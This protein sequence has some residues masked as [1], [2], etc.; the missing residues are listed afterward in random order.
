MQDSMSIVSARGFWTPLDKTY[1]DIRVFHPQAPSNASKTITQMYHHHETSKKREYNARVIQVEKGTCTP[2][3][4]STTG[5]MGV[6]AD[7]FFKRLALKMSYKNDISYI[8]LKQH[9]FCSKTSTIRS[10]QNNPYL[11][12]RLQGKINRPMEDT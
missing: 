8:I 7:L 4:F 11:T 1:T 10:S 6:E 3:V 9:Q 2:L 12:Q 5:G